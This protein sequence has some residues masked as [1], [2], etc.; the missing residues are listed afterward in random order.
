M[1]TFDLNS[2]PR[3]PLCIL[4]TPITK[5][6]N[7]SKI[8]GSN[9]FVKRDDLTGVAFGGNKNRKLEFL[10]ADALAKNAD[11]IIT[12]G[13]VQSNHCLQ[14]AA[15]ASKVGLDCE[16]VLSGSIE[17]TI[18]GNLLL[19]RILD[20]TL[21]VVEDA[22]KRKKTMMERAI[23]LEHM[24]KKVY[25]IPTGGSTDIG[26]LGYINCVKEIQEY[27]K[28]EKISFNSIVIATGSGGTHA[29]FLLGCKFYYP[30][31]NVIAITAAD[32]KQDMNDQVLHI[33][34]DF[35]KSHSLEFDLNE[36]TCTIFDN[37]FGQ[38]YGIPTKEVINTIKMV[39][40][41]EGL[42]LDPVYNGKAMVGLIDMLKKEML[43]KDN[44][45]LFLHSGGGPSLFNYSDYF[46]N[47]SDLNE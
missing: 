16:L 25:I 21:H 30:D 35:Q 6:E 26:S 3:T 38:G 32:N 14:T 2:I 40:K 36:F 8:V 37:Y 15:C 19:N 46:D 47:N 31:C 7:L 12:E 22:S 28:R 1:V 42:F 13:A 11:V 45:Y 18:S 23:S 20:T 44:K 17:N 24:G 33:I 4:P 39:A 27:S 29:G 41:E 5:M 34:K 9:I 10:L 43:P